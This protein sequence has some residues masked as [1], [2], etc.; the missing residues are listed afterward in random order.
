MREYNHLKVEKLDVEVQNAILLESIRM[1]S[2]DVT[3]EEWDPVQD[4]AGNDF[5]KVEFE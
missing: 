1:S 3:V 4:E 2:V 5:F